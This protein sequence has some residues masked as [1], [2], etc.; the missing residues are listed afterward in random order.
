MSENRF[1]ASLNHPVYLIQYGFIRFMSWIVCL[2]PFPWALMMTSPIG[3]ILFLVL[4]RSRKM[5]FQNLKNAFPEKNEA[6]IKSMA[7]AAFRH[8]AVFGIEWL[9]MPEMIKNSK[10][11]LIDE[12][13]GKEKIPEGLT[14]KRGAILLVTH[15]ANWEVMALML[16]RLLT[17]QSVGA[18]VY[19][20]ARPLKNAR[21][22]RYA[23]KMRAGEGLQSI[24]KSGGVRETFDRL[25]K[26]NA[27][28]CVVI[29]QRISEGSIEID[30]FGR[31]ALTTTLPVMAALRLGTPVYF[32]F[33]R[34][35]DDLRYEL[36]IEG[37]IP[38][39]RT[40][41]FK[42]DIAVNTQNFATRAEAEIR[43]NPSHWLW[44][45]NRW[46]VAHGPK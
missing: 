13:I 18:A 15:T 42:K 38:I 39:M 23:V 33:I 6:E 4:K 12:V 46:R 28:V 24:S 10:K 30:F 41:D 35:T 8:L 45:H 26:D 20:V 25:R 44:M 11:Y 27:A 17:T 34:Q 9:M 14:K 1:P 16:G 43:K 40:G 32:S 29:D 31:P 7:Q 21:L 19:A 2:I 37:P 5:T 36:K 3:A 22:Y